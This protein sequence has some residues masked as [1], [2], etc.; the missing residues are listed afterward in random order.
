MI[1]SK[2]TRDYVKENTILKGKT[3]TLLVLSVHTSNWGKRVTYKIIED[4]GDVFRIS[5]KGRITYGVCLS[6]LYGFEIMEV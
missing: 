5:L 1:L 2:E 6:E 4:N 3:M